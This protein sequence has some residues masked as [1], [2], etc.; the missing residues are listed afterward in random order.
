MVASLRGWPLCQG[1]GC[2]FGSISDCTPLRRTR[3]SRDAYFIRRSSCVGT[4]PPSAMR[5]SSRRQSHVPAAKDRDLG[6]DSING[7]GN[8]SKSASHRTKGHMIWI[9][10]RGWDALRSSWPPCSATGKMCESEVLG[11]A[12]LE[13]CACISRLKVDRT[14]TV[15][16][17]HA[18]EQG[19]SNDNFDNG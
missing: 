10:W 15:P 13:V 5:T 18:G 19:I 3:H 7:S 9:L 17:A 6:S 8:G 16:T 1:S 14:G 4:D 2:G 12:C 11:L